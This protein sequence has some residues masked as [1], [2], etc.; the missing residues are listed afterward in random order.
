[1]AKISI[2]QTKCEFDEGCRMCLEI[3]STGVFIV[4]SLKPRTPEHGPI[5]FRVS[6]I[7]DTLCIECDECVNHC[8]SGA[9]SVRH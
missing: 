5:G 7:L 1:M 9:I 8:K 4:H 6:P 3:C 2:D